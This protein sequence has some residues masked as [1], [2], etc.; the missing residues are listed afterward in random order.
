MTAVHQQYNKSGIGGACFGPH[1]SLNRHVI[2]SARDLA[3]YLCNAFSKQYSKRQEVTA[4]A[5]TS[6]ARR[7]AK[8]AHAVKGAASNNMLHLLTSTTACILQAAASCVAVRCLK[9][10]QQQLKATDSTAHAA[11]EPHLAI[12]PAA[13]AARCCFKHVA[14]AGHHTWGTGHLRDEVVRICNPTKQQQHCIKR[15]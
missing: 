7:V 9:Q 2:W 10:Q 5:Q 13:D 1:L 11:V 8:S 3:P 6:V 14:S 15:H 4:L 12:V